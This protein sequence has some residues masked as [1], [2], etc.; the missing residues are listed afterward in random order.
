M[1]LSCQLSSP[2]TL[3]Q[4]FISI[5]STWSPA[6]TESPL[7]LASPSCTMHVA[8][9]L[10]I[11]QTVLESIFGSIDPPVLPAAAPVIVTLSPANLPKVSK[12]ISLPFTPPL[13]HRLSSPPHSPTPLHTA[14]L[15]S[16]H[17]QPQSSFNPSSLNSANTLIFN[18]SRPLTAS[19]RVYTGTLPVNNSNESEHHLA[20]FSSVPSSLLSV[21]F[22]SSPSSPITTVTVTL[23]KQTSSSPS[24]LPPVNIAATLRLAYILPSSASNAPINTL[25]SQT[26]SIH[27]MSLIASTENVTNQSDIPAANVRIIS[28]SPSPIHILMQF[29]PPR[30]LSA[31]NP[32]VPLASLVK[33]SES[34][35]LQDE[36]FHHLTSLTSASSTSASLAD[37]LMAAVNASSS[38]ISSLN[39]MIIVLG[40][41]AWVFVNAI[42]IVVAFVIAL[43]MIIPILNKNNA[44]PQASPVV[45]SNS[46]IYSGA[47]AQPSYM[48]ASAVLRTPGRHHHGLRTP[49]RSL[50]KVE[51]PLLMAGDNNESQESMT[52]A[53]GQQQQ[54]PYYSSSYCGERVIY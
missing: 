38:S 32:N 19:F 14:T 13:L 8:T 4:S 45:S 40:S 18:P 5:T 7:P 37:T 34:W 31:A 36:T 12:S 11:Q 2:S 3:M 1:T 28:L 15:S 17:V 10:E 33:T 23:N 22:H 9:P 26:A 27:N 51:S 47:N 6:P 53:S 49:G 29:A 44:P 41:Y 39:S 35:T 43:R 46:S 52:D 25:D 20:V 42:G 21:S 50:I 24:P 30:S 54:Q 16:V 48:P